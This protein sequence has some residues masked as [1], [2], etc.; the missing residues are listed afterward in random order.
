MAAFVIV[1][2]FSNA[3]F[4]QLHCLRTTCVTG[5]S[6]HFRYIVRYGMQRR[7][8]ENVEAQ[9]SSI[10]I[11]GVQNENLSPSKLSDQNVQSTN[12]VR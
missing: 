4:G 12:S 9:R 2:E 11:C 10:E 1:V 6:W 8:R 3:R 7:L 5:G